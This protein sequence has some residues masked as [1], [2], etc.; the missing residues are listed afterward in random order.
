MQN[1]SPTDLQL[2]A[3]RTDKS[4]KS[5]DKKS[6]S[7]RHLP[8]SNGRN[9][10]QTKHRDRLSQRE[11]EMYGQQPSKASKPIISN[12]SEVVNNSALLVS[13]VE[14]LVNQ[15]SRCLDKATVHYVS[16]NRS[17]VKKSAE[18]RNAFS[19]IN[20]ITR[21][22]NFYIECMEDTFYYGKSDRQREELMSGLRC[23]NLEPLKT[24]VDQLER[25]FSKS[26]ER[27]QQ[28]EEAYN[29]SKKSLVKASEFCKLKARQAKDSEFRTKVIGGSATA[30]GGAATLGVGVLAG[31]GTFGIGTLLA[32]GAIAVVS[33]GATGYYTYHSVTQPQQA[34]RELEKLETDFNNMEKCASKLKFEVGIVKCSLISI[35]RIVNEIKGT[36]E[37]CASLLDSIDLLN[38]KFKEYYTRTN[39]CRQNLQELSLED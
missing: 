20:N 36:E 5:K 24:Y 16:A 11:N 26:E 17:V 19:D 23:N 10:P 31:I 7:N 25:C 21:L 12:F 15:L 22:A 8:A 27:Y 38:M 6:R 2:Q 4:V 32:V 13:S 9:S 30:L 3:S 18:A 29:E 34:V 1:H 37:N 28:F 35:S 14:S 33:T 39:S